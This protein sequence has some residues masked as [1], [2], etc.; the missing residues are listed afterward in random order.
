MLTVNR[1]EFVKHP[2]QSKRVTFKPQEMP[3][4]SSSKI[5]T[6]TSY[7]EDFPPRKLDPSVR[8]PNKVLLPTVQCD[9][10]SIADN[11]VTTNQK[12]LKGWTGLH[13]QSAYGEPESQKLFHGDFDGKSTFQND[14]QARSGRPSTSCKQAPTVHVS[15]NAEFYD[16]TT[17]RITYTLPKIVEKESLHLR[18]HAKKNKESLSPNANAGKMDTLSQ[19]Q[20]DNPGFSRLPHKQS[21]CEPQPD[22]LQLFNGP[23][24]SQTETMACYNPRHL[25]NA[26]QRE[27]FK[28]DQQRHTNGGHFDDRTSFKTDFQPIPLDK[29]ACTKTIGNSHMLGTQA[30]L[31]Q[32]FGEGFSKETTNKVHFQPWEVH[33]RVCYGDRAERMFRPSNQPFKGKS[34]TKSSFIPIATKPSESCKPLDVRFGRRSTAAYERMASGTTYGDHFLPKPLPYRK[35]CPVELLLR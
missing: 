33:P 30:K 35:Q 7:K 21:I 22:T 25:A 24:L 28:M 14:F 17:N 11:Y 3:R 16:E 32:D 4:L 1:K 18:K 15:K 12:M 13:Y 26:V 10:V 5:Q 9:N 8:Q 2:I 34:E 20:Q 23:Q 19:Y 29:V 27:S 6:N 31:A